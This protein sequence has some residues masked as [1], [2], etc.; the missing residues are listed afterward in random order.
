MLLYLPQ[1]DIH[2]DY[3]SS[4]GIPIYGSSQAPSVLLVDMDAVHDDII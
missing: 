3:W 2:D 1:I 4:F